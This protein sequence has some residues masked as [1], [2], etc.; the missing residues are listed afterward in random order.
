MATTFNV[1]HL[2]NH[3]LIEGDDFTDGAE[4]AE[5]LLGMTFGSDSDP[6][7]NHFH[8]FEPF[9]TPDD[10]TYGDTLLDGYDMFEIDG[11]FPQIF[12]ASATYI[13][14]LT[15]VDGSTENVS[16]VVF[17]DDEGETYIAPEATQNADM[18]A[19]EAKPIQSISLQSVDYSADQDMHVDLQSWNYAVCFAAGLK[20]QTPIG[21][22]AVET[23]K[24]GD[25][26]LTVDNGAQPIIWSGT[27]MQEVTDSNRPIRIVAGAFGAGI[28]TRDLVVS[29]QHRV[30]VKLPANNEL[31]P[32]EVLVPAAKLT[33]LPGV[34]ADPTYEKVRYCHV[35]CPKHEIVIA[36]GAEVETLYIGKMAEEALGEEMMAEIR[37]AC[38]QHGIEQLDP[39]RDL[40]DGSE[41]ADLAAYFAGKKKPVL[42]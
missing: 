42:Q 40:L 35:L 37:E 23:L 12:D 1:L 15:Y 36:H 24:I 29:P 19:L 13:A 9:S 33:A 39:A 2:G 26:V 4:N 8:T 32:K 30:L 14:T 10:S 21:E 17:Q 5:D 41:S 3:T 16:V 28:P 7:Y 25:E 22:A 11:G 20:L 6:L 34:Y 27:A 18:S 38:S 31:T